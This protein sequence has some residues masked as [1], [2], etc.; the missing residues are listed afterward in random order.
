M[1]FDATIQARTPLPNGLV[2]NPGQSVFVAEIYLKRRDILPLS[3]QAPRSL[4]A[5][6]YF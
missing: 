3:A 2:L 1:A 6:A 5:A 4:Y